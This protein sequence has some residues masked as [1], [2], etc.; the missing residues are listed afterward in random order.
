M[1]APAKLPK[2]GRTKPKYNATPTARE[3]AHWEYVRQQGCLVSGS[4][5]VTIHHVTGFA[6]RPG[7][8]TRS[9]RLIVPL[10]PEYHLIQHDK[11]QTLSVEALGHQGFFQEWGIDLLAEAKRLEAESVAAGRL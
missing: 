7:R 2:H 3:R 1:N 10:R 5:G 4:H 11:H 9:H 6:D 8:F